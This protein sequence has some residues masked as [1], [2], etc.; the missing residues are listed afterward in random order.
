MIALTV[1]YFAFKIHRLTEQRQPWF[2]GTGF[3]LLA[4]SYLIQL[5]ITE[6]FLLQWND[7][8]E[9]ELVNITA[10]SLSVVGVYVYMSFFLAGL[11][12]IAYM[13][14][15]IKSARA[16]LLMLAMGLTGLVASESQLYLFFFLSTIILSF[17]LFHYAIQLIKSRHLTNLLVL[18][19]FLFFLAGAINFLLVPHYVGCLIIGNVLEVAGMVLILINLILVTRK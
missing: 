16:Y 7:F 18:V 6:A 5:V 14:L 9:G 10:L 2:F 17:I 3:V 12:T 1:S 11:I 13:T 4:I 8:I 19:A 15:N